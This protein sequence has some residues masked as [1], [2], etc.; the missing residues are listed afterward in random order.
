MEGGRFL[1]SEVTHPARIRLPPMRW[2][3]CIIAHHD[4]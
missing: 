2:G 3:I 4:T 1:M